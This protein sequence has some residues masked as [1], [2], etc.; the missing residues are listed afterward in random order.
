M[1]T[2]IDCF[3]ISLNLDPIS[4][5]EFLA[6]CHEH[7]IEHDINLA[8]LSSEDMGVLCKGSSDATFT[9]AAAA[10]AAAGMLVEGWARGN[11]LR[12]VPAW[13]NAFARR[14]KEEQW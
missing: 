9:F 8:V 14:G 1:A 3:I 4:G 7:G 2:I 13:A 11:A 6:C 12:A 5:Q 10:Q